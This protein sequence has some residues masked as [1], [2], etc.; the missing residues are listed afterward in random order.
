MTQ[1]RTY[2]DNMDLPICG[3]F[4]KA[5]AQAV[6]LFGSNIWV[7]TLLVM[8]VLEGFH[9]CSAYRI[10]RVKPPDNTHRPGCGSA[11]HWLWCWMKWVCPQSHTMCKFVDRPSLSIFWSNLFLVSVGMARD[12]KIQVLDS[13]GGNSLLIGIW[14][15]GMYRRLLELMIMNRGHQQSGV[16]MSTELVWGESQGERIEVLFT[17]G[18]NHSSCANMNHIFSIGLQVICFQC[19]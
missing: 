6:L 10:T 8:K 2:S 9:I 11:C 12:N 1:S 18:D 5:V 14:Q 4:Y 7:L 15:G 16:G 19:Y 3:M 13:G 17:C